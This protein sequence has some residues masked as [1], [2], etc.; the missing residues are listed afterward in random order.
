MTA[1]VYPDLAATT[2]NRKWILEVN[3]A[4]TGEATYTMVGGVTDF[5]PVADDANW[6]DDSDFTNGGFQSQVK[7]STA[8][9]ATCTVRRAPT[10]DDAT[11]YDVGQEALRTRAI[12]KFG[13]DN[14]AEVRFY[15]YDPSDPTGANS[16]R[17]EAYHGF[18]G[19]G[20]A[21]QGGAYNAISTVQVTLT[22]QGRLDIIEHP[23]PA[24]DSSS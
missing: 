16:P 4:D 2:V 13:N 22:G 11:V 24:S 9:S 8:W 17:V 21:E 5:Q 3:T 6:V 14:R 7:T 15:E 20:W 10:S 18:A 23:F 1:P 19:V 12:G